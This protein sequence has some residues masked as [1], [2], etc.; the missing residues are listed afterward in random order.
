MIGK[1]SPHLLHRSQPLMI[2]AEFS[3][4]FGS[5]TRVNSKV[6]LHGHTKSSKSVSF[7]E[8]STGD[9]GIQQ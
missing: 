2:S 7:I 1:F 9:G 6:P 3:E 4:L 5:R 8:V